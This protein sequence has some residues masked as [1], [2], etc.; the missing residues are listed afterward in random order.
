MR[1]SVDLILVH[2]KIKDIYR[3]YQE[4]QKDRREYIGK[5]IN[6]ENDEDPYKDKYRAYYLKA[7]NIEK[8]IFRQKEN[9]YISYFN[10]PEKNACKNEPE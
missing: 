9:S 8:M 6:P 5:M 1:V 7:E 2:K 4:Y 3:K 10:D